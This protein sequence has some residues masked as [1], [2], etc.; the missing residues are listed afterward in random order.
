M[1]YYISDLNLFHS[2]S[3]KFDN[4]PFDSVEEMHE[5][6]RNR[7]NEKVTTEIWCIYLAIL[8]FAVKMRI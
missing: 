5:T 8:A 1:K 2:N 3:I 4:R 7:W 6:I